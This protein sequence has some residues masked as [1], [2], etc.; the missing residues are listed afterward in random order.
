LNFKFNQ[1][2]AGPNAT[3]VFEARGLEF[4]G[5]SVVVPAS[6]AMNFTSVNVRGSTVFEDRPDEKIDVSYKIISQG[7]DYNSTFGTVQVLR[8]HA[9]GGTCQ[10]GGDPH[11][12]TFDGYNFDSQTP[13][14]YKLFSHQNLEIQTVQRPWYGGNV[15]SNAAI[16]IRYGRSL[17]A[18]DASAS[19]NDF[20]YLTSLNNNTDG[21][22]YIK[23]TSTTF[24]GGLVHTIKFSCGTEMKLIHNY[25]NQFAWVDVTLVLGPGYS[26]YGGLCNQVTPTTANQLFNASGAYVSRGG[27]SEAA[28]I[29]SWK[30]PTGKEILGG[31]SNLADADITGAYLTCTLPNIQVPPP[32]PI[33]PPCNRYIPPT[34]NNTIP[35]TN[36][37]LP[38]NQTLPH[39]DTFF[40]QTV[41]YCDR[42]FKDN[43]CNKVVSPDSFVLACRAD[44][45]LTGNYQ[46]AE[47]L[48][49]AYFASCQAKCGLM[50][51]D[52]KPEIVQQAVA[53]Q[54]KCGLSGFECPNKCSQHGICSKNGCVCMPG[55]SGPDCS[56]DLATLITYSP[57]NATYVKQAPVDY[58]SK[59]VPASAYN[60]YITA[61]SAA[62]KQY[63]SPVAH[64]MA[65][66]ASLPTSATGASST[67]A[68]VISGASGV[69]FAP[70][71][72]ALIALFL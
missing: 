27:Q 24:H 11:I 1:T 13:G 2:L 66:P 35:Q 53:V 41:S 56:I 49:S 37:T 60:Q 63:D 8:K 22:V 44:S 10:N 59:P 70:A 51:K 34:L 15:Q 38:Q 19:Q 7:M 4:P 18:F 25:A 43:D 16:G 32:A 5:C 71:A 65:Y 20:V 40:N 72:L 23:P 26:N 61:Q 50:V 21:V 54:E 31:N 52:T 47:G 36:Q 6:G 30:V 39:N 33:V 17:F 67:V 68:P 3:V 14:T 48:K 62:D 29:Q 9:K 55:F 64:P 42:L 28:F 45:L 12:V 46:F 58:N 57:Q 69:N